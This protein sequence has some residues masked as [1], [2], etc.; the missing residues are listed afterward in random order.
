MDDNPVHTKHT[1]LIPLY[2]YRAA[3]SLWVSLGAVVHVYD[4]TNWAKCRQFRNYGAATAYVQW[5]EDWH[6]GDTP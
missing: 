5:I 1:M 6:K 4:T 3:E 2:T